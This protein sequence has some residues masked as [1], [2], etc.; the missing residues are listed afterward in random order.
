MR[1]SC[2]RWITNALC[3]LSLLMAES[4]P[5]AAQEPNPKKVGLVLSGGGARGAA[6]IGLLKIL[7]R[8]QIPIDLIV[9]TS[10]G[11]VV[12]GLYCLGYTAVQ[13]EQLLLRQDW[14]SLFSD[15]PERRFAPLVIQKSS[16]YMGQVSFQGWS[17]ELPTGLYGGQKLTEALDRLTTERI[18]AVRYDFDRLPIPF[19]AVATNLIDG[20]AYIFK[21]GSMTEALRASIA[22][23]MLFTP[24]D[25]DGMLLVDGGLVDNLPTD[26][27]RDMGADIV[28]A[29]D[30]TSPLLTKSEIRT[31]VDVLDQS[32]SLL[33]VQNT[34]RNRR[35]ADLIITPDLKNYSY[36]NYTQ[37]RQIEERGEEEAEKRLVEVKKLVAG[38]PSRPHP[39][40]IPT[41]EKEIIVSVSFQGL[42][43]V[44][45]SQL[46]GDVKSKSGEPVNPQKLS[47][48]LGRLYATQLFENVDYD[49]EPAGTNRY[50][51]VFRVKEAP[52]HILGASIRYD[53]SYKFV[54]LA[55]FTARQL[56]GTPSTATLSGQFG[57]IENYSAALRY[58]PGFAPFLFVEPKARILRRE[59]LDI[60]DQV[61]VDRFTD[62][63][64]GGE[65]MVGGTFFKRLEVAAGYT[66]DS[67]SISGGA[68]P[69]QLSG[70]VRLAGLALRIDRDTLDAQDFPHTG[71][72]LRLLGQKRSDSLGSD[73]SYT[74]L[75]GDF[76]RFFSPTDKS[77]FRLGISAGVS[78]GPVPFYDKFYLGG[79]TF[80]EGG[81]TRVLGLDR[82]ELAVNQM[83]L[84]A[85]SYR[86]LI[87]SKPLSFIRHAYASGFYNL[88]AYSDRETSPYQFKL[89]NGA[90]IGLALDTLLGP[91]SIAGGWGEGGRFHF[92]LSLGPAF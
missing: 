7:E 73:L 34:I 70:S 23:P 63:R 21:Q 31:F 87:L 22:I 33:M 32:L 35:L 76:E 10:F 65:L 37:I 24:L 88:I 36:S 43:Y 57:G 6:H 78:R 59:R 4:L 74:L 20:K 53:N 72:A 89:F 2:H 29:S 28:I 85:A 83:G 84:L 15:A 62:R 27:A 91:M 69:N 60:R 50:N 41:G 67:V 12:G 54:A 3:I 55:E 19:R 90:G 42:E 44:K 81:P 40:W 39:P 47:D 38:L 80:S 5:A 71:S 79:Y 86:R 11:A 51:V 48:D 45:A 8:E 25:K 75:Q 9:G 82:D 77:T 26:I 49:L 14:N 16:R 30:T 92:Y 66:D 68:P 17:P 52:R 18:V 61:L 64:S 13:I 46:R 58:I 1:N 56:F